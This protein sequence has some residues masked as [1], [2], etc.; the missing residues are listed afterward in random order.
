MFR[1]ARNVISVWTDKKVC[2]IWFEETRFEVQLSVFSKGHWQRADL[3]LL[4]LG[5][6]EPN[7]F[8][9]GDL[10]LQGSH[11]KAASAVLRVFFD[12]C[13]FVRQEE[14]LWIG[15]GWSGQQ[16]DLYRSW[17]FRVG[18]FWKESAGS[19]WPRGS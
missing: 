11:R 17:M 1:E 9:I 13:H 2:W 14:Q 6:L 4:E 7:G 19:A 3:K 8:E 18:L 16:D 12:I 10:F 5:R 15:D